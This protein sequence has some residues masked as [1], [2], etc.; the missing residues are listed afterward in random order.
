MDYKSD[1]KG[2]FNLT[3]MLQRVYQNLKHLSM[4]NQLWSNPSP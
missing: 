3:K 1:L 2:L 4:E